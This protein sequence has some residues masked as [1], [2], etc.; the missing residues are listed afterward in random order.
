MLADD[1]D[2]ADW[3]FTSMQARYILASNADLSCDIEASEYV[4]ADD[5]APSTGLARQVT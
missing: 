3:C 1:M 5:K 4:V 2:W